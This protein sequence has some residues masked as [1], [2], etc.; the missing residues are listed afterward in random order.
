MRKERKIVELETS[1]KDFLECTSVS[2]YI[3]LI[4]SLVEC[5]SQK[6][7]VYRGEPEVYSAPCR[8][9]I[10]R[11]GVLNNNRLYERSLFDT[12]RQNGLTSEK[13]YL[14]NAIDAQ[15]GEFPSRLLDVTY[16]CL[17]ALY[18]A[19]TAF[20]H[21]GDDADDDKD[22]MVYVFYM[23]DIYSPSANNTN[24]V[25]NAIISKDIP[26]FTDEIIFEKNHKFI[27]H[28]KINKRIVAQQGAFILFQGNDATPIPKYMH[29]GILIPKKYKPNLR[30]ELK[31][32]F[33]IHTG[34]IYPEI[35]NLANELNE[36]SKKI[37]NKEFSCEN[38][39]SQVMDTFQKELDYY[40]DYLLE[41][42]NV[43]CESR[44]DI[45]KKIDYYAA[46]DYVE[47]LIKSYRI[48][49]LDYGSRIKEKY[50][51]LDDSGKE[52]EN[53]ENALKRAVQEY[54]KKLF[55][56]QEDINMYNLEGI[57]IENLGIDW[58]EEETK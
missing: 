27:D 41:C 22:G 12:M 46:V 34:S 51:N 20:Y 21:R 25:Y 43:F 39:F 24:Q 26:W 35:T 8:P 11:K 16:N 45:Q 40:F 32:Y 44:N 14:D 10:F 6:I 13:R 36:K 15:H 52:F 7:V 18:F 9:N 58:N 57:S 1:K 54:Q 38:E 56:F 48:G 29:Q 3:E 2:Q 50:R 47:K 28:C 55:N 19:V 4:S 30:N 42:Y 49:L 5:T 37:V 23:D 53:I 31:L 17:V 33:G